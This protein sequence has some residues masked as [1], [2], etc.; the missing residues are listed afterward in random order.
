MAEGY[1]FFQHESFHSNL[2]PSGSVCHLQFNYV[3]IPNPPLLR[4]R[5]GGIGSTT[6]NNC[7][8]INHTRHHNKLSCRA[9]VRHLG[10][11]ETTNNL[12]SVLCS[13]SFS[14]FSGQNPSTIDIS[15]LCSWVCNRNFSPRRPGSGCKEVPFKK[16]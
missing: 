3:Q 13:H 6:G 9:C 2:M 7:S 14:V 15:P 4:T 8:G 12:M 16:R 11:K 10:Q 1:A 5:P